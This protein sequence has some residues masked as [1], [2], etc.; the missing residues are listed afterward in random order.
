MGRANLT[1]FVE[2]FF[3]PQGPRTEGQISLVTQ[4]HVICAATRGKEE[5]WAA[6]ASQLFRFVGEGT[7]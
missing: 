3:K 4:N 5:T 6:G 2:E 1:L 7:M